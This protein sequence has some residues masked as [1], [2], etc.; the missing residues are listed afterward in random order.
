M[1]NSGDLT[2]AMNAQNLQA[3]IEDIYRIC[4]EGDQCGYFLQGGRLED[5]EDIRNEISELK[6]A[7]DHAAAHGDE[8][9]TNDRWVLAASTLPRIK[10]ELQ[11]CVLAADLAQEDNSLARAPKFG[12][13]GDESYFS[14]V[15]K[16][17]FA[18]AS[19]V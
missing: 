2:K 16:V 13:N 7:F 4:N 12:R 11:A 5:F 15:Q 9:S 14:S 6:K 18:P 3:D 17:L 10:S 8:F 19:R 1:I